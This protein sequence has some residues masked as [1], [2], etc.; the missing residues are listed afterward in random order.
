MGEQS[1]D[2]LNTE[3]RAFHDRF[4]A[5]DLRIRNDMTHDVTSK[6]KEVCF[7]TLSLLLSRRFLLKPVVMMQTT[8][9]RTRHDTEVIWN[10]VSIVLKRHRQLERWL[11]NAWPQGHVWPTR[12][13]KVA[14]FHHQ[15]A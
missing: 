6:V 10:A 7:L 2:M 3:T 11:W 9:D 12:V 1:Q 15:E 13:V 14:P 8:Q 4:P 5:E